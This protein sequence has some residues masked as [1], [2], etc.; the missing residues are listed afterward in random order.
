MGVE[1]GGIGA[2][3]VAVSAL[4]GVEMS[5]VR[6]MSTAS[7]DIGFGGGESGAG[8]Y[9]SA[10][11]CLVGGAECGVLVVVAVSESTRRA[12]KAAGARGRRFGV[13]TA[14][15]AAGGVVRLARVGPSGEVRVGVDRVSGR[16]VDRGVRPPCGRCARRSGEITK[17]LC[18]RPEV[19]DVD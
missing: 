11:N 12:G 14:G 3:W 17:L 19:G 8:S 4:A 16:A 13:E 6:A 7:A 18:V 5:A 9:G 2:C 10:N 15:V 1:F